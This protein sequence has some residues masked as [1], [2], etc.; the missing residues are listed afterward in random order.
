[1]KKF[2]RNHYTRLDHI[3]LT[4]LTKDSA[5]NF[6]QMKQV[7]LNLDSIKKLNSCVAQDLR[8]FKGDLSLN[9]LSELDQEIAE[10]LIPRITG[11]LHFC[12]KIS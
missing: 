9:G 1:M 4:R 8:N 12:F 2:N 10:Y 11:R 7:G 6:A 5:K 3:G